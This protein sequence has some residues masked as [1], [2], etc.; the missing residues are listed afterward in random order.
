MKRLLLFA[1]L[2]CP[3]F[4]A[5]PASPSDTA[6]AA[7]AQGHEQVFPTFTGDAPISIVLQRGDKQFVIS[8]VTGVR[9]VGSITVIS[10]N[11]GR[12]YSISPADILFITDDTFGLK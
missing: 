11:N 9:A 8:G 10:V 4:A 1:A 5:T 7:L 3:L 2:T 12:K 6:L